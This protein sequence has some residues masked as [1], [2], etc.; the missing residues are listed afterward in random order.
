MWLDIPLNWIESQVASYNEK[1]IDIEKKN[2]NLFFIIKIKPKTCIPKFSSFCYLLLL[3]IRYFWN[4]T[5]GKKII[6]FY[7]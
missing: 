2:K 3:L 4:L 7:F 6:F 1:K 5:E